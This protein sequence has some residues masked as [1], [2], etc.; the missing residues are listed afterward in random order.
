M[1][2]GHD[3]SFVT[4]DGAGNIKLWRNGACEVTQTGGCE[5]LAYYGV[6]L[7]VI[8]RRLI[9]AGVRNTLLVAE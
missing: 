9:V 7:A 2:A 6:P 8:G 5:G 4:A 3:G 1:L